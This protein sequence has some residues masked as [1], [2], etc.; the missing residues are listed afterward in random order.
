MDG[1]K[2]KALLPSGR[3]GVVWRSRRTTLTLAYRRRKEIY[4]SF[5]LK[6]AEHSIRNIREKAAYAIR[7]VT[8]EKSQRGRHY[9]RTGIVCGR[10]MADEA[11][12]EKGQHHACI[13]T[14]NQWHDQSPRP[15]IQV[16][17]SFCRSVNKPFQ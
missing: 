12:V 11:C 17:F 16:P 8:N 14:P 3:K 5:F 9:H 7:K 10:S 13:D 15:T 1:A 6:S 4:R 2:P